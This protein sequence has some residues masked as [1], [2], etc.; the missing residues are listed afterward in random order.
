ML[1]KIDPYNHKE[2]YLKWKEN[3]SKGIPEISKESSDI[4][5]QYLN[6]MEIG[7]NVSIANKKGGRSYIRLNS[8]KDRLIFFSKKF[9]ELYGLNKITEINEEQI[10]AFFSGMLKG[11]IKRKDGK[12]YTA[13]D[14]YSK[15]FKAYWHW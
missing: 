9:N 10:T 7:R 3:V 12:D 5:L 11:T 6:D 15:V 13:V 1:E 2:R 14:S 8:I 4:I